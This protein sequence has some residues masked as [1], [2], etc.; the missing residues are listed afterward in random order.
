MPS[1]KISDVFPILN[2]IRI[3]WQN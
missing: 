1:C 3:Y 2:K